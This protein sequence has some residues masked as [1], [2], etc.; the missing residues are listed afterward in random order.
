MESY[1]FQ[2]PLAYREIKTSEEEKQNKSLSCDAK[3]DLDEFFVL[4]NQTVEERSKTLAHL[5]M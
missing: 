1:A 4:N 3:N 5:M 2:T